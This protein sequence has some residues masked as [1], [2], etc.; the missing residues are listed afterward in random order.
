VETQSQT[1]RGLSDLRKRKTGI[2]PGELLCEHP[3]QIYRASAFE[4]LRTMTAD[5]GIVV[6]VI[7]SVGKCAGFLPVGCGNLVA[8]I[9]CLLVLFVECKNLA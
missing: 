4:K 1:A 8:A 3:V 7:S 6:R 5:A 9:A 2:I